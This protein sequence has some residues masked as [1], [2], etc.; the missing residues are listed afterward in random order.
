MSKCALTLITNVHSFNVNN[1]L[2]QKNKCPPFNV[3]FSPA[4]SLSV[5]TWNAAICLEDSPCAE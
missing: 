3:L 1:F 4:D 2:C 5:P